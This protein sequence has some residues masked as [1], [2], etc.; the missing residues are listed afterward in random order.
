MLDL[1]VFCKR[2]AIGNRGTPMFPTAFCVNVIFM[3]K[4]A[5]KLPQTIES[6][7]GWVI[8]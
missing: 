8:L 4:R 5:A 2:Q 3:I 1:S 7:Q 6:I